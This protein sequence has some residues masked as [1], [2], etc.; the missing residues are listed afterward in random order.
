MSYNL[1]SDY[2]IDPLNRPRFYGVYRASVLNNVDPEGKKR[3]TLVV[4]QITGSDTM[5]LVPPCVSSGAL[6]D[7]R[8]PSIGESVWVIFESGD[9]GY[10]LWITDAGYANRTY[11]GY[12]GSFTSSVRQTSTTGVSTITFDA[13]QISNGVSL[14][15]GSQIKVANA[16]TYNFQ[17]GGQI[18]QTVNGSPAINIWIRKNGVDLVPG[19]TWQFDL[20][21]QNHFSVPAFS[22]I[23]TLAAGDYIEFQ[24]TSTSTVY[25][26]YF[27][28]HTTAPIYPATP[29][30]VVNVIQV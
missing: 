19:S 16:G 20:S 27:A 14:V 13:T 30:A 22:Y 25:L 4:P 24:W 8:V 29:S 18:H 2:S 21:N 7:T 11:L 28:E 3:L 23:L 26:D 9:P 10:P 6:A 1:Y 15:S 5:V 12:C 17:F